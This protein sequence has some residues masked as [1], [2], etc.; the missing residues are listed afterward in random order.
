M[1]IPL[2]GKGLWNIV[3]GKEKVSDLEGP[4]LISE[5]VGMGKG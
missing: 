5:Y 1:R 3:N 4:I 2:R